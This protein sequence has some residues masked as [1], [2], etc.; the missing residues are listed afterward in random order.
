[1]DFVAKITVSLL[2]HLYIQWLDKKVVSFDQGSKKIFSQRLSPAPLI[3]VFGLFSGNTVSFTYELL[4]ANVNWYCRLLPAECMNGQGTA[5]DVIL[6]V[7]LCLP[8]IWTFSCL[9]FLTF[10]CFLFTPP[11][12]L[13]HNKM[14]FTPSSNS[15]LIL[16]SYGWFCCLCFH[17]FFPTHVEQRRDKACSFTLC[18]VGL[19]MCVFVCVVVWLLVL[20]YIKRGVRDSCVTLVT[21][22]CRSARQAASCCISSVF[23]FIC[24]EWKGREVLCWQPALLPLDC[25]KNINVPVSRNTAS[26]PLSV[27]FHVWLL[28]KTSRVVWV[29]LPDLPRAWLKALTGIRVAWQLSRQGTHKHQCILYTYKHSHTLE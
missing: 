26:T 8:F 20:K 11:A 28:E 24:T 15:F 14:S 19:D 22:W 7:R 21:W 9:S 6:A 12:V 3:T 23:V 10:V 29:L 13:C 5:V 2:K 18:D 25:R 27:S 1:M 4:I 16:S 17:S